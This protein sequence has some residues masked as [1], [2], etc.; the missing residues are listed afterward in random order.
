MANDK[1][2]KQKGSH[3]KASTDENSAAN[4]GENSAADAPKSSA[5]SVFGNSANSAQN[6]AANSTT[7]ASHAR[8][9]ISKNRAAGENSCD[10]CDCEAKNSAPSY[11]DSASSASSTNFAARSSAQSASNAQNSAIG[12]TTNSM[13]D[14]L[15]N[16]I[17][18]PAK[19]PSSEDHFSCSHEHSDSSA[20]HSH[21]HDEDLAT[22]PHDQ[23]EN[24]AA[25]LHEYGANSAASSHERD[26][27]S[28]ISSHEH[29]K[30][31][32]DHKP[33]SHRA[34]IGFDEHGIPKVLVPAEASPHPHKDAQGN[35]FEHFHEAEFTADYMKAV[36]EYKKT[37]PTKQEVLEKTPDPAVREMMLRMEQIGV[38]TAFDRFDKQMPMCSYGLTGVC[39]KICNMGPCKITKKA[40]RGTCGADADLIVSRNLL[41]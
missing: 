8:D 11:D 17:S 28:A 30:H 24:L 4:T 6:S 27:D 32:H 16:S 10:E 34:I 19:S 40:D 7:S 23:E 3:K 31:C 2:A 37:F 9:K 38:D 36:L 21:L 33:H 18:N 41:R 12:S 15:T 1:I 25:Y 35:L 39:C 20:I 26:E 22:H 5:A 13:A 29:D 14:S